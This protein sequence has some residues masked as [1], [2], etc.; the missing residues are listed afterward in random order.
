MPTHFRKMKSLRNKTKKSK[1]KTESSQTRKKCMNDDEIGATCKT[2][3]YSSYVGNFYKNKDHLKQFKLIG[4]RF[5]S[6]KEYNKWKTPQEKYTHFLKTV[7]SP[8][9]SISKNDYLIT[10]NFYGY[11]NNIWL[12][13]TYNENALKSND[14]SK[15]KSKKDSPSMDSIVVSGSNDA[16]Q[17]KYYVQHD[18]FRIKQEE[19]Y[20]KLIGY[21]TDYIAAN[22]KSP[23]AKALNCIY[24]SLKNGSRERFSLHAK[25]VVEEMDKFI[26]DDDVYGCLAALNS[27][28]TVNWCAPILWTLLPNEKNVKQ[29]ISH[30]YA[31]SL[32]IYD[33]QIYLED[34]NKTKPED[35]RYK[36]QVRAKYFEYIQR[37]FDACLGAQKAAANNLNAAD[38]WGVELELLTAMNCDEIKDEDPNGYNLLTDKDLENPDTFDFDWTQ[39]TKKLGYTTTPTKIVVGNKSSI[40]CLIRIMK[41]KWK[42]PAWRAYLMFIQFKQ[43]IRFDIHHRKIHFDFYNNFLE[44]QPS[45]MPKEIYPIFGLSFTFNSFLSEQYVEHNYNALYASYTQHLVDDLKQ[46]FINKLKRNTWLSPETKVAALNKL[47]KLVIHVGTPGKLREDPI[48]P[49]VDDDPLS[50]MGLLLKWKLKKTI[51]LE[52]KPIIDVPDID[53]QAFKLV[54]TQCYMVNAYYRPNSNS[55]YVP[56]AYL[57]KPFIDLEERG[58]EYNLVYIGYTLGHELSHALDDTGSKYDAE[59]NLNNWWTPADHKKFQA[60]VDDVIKQYEVFSLRDGIVF[61]AA[62]GAGEDLADI[63]GYALI[64]EYLMDNQVINAEDIKMKKINLSK[65][66]MNLAIQG[67][68]YVNKK[69]VKAQLKM[70]PH[71]MEK[72]RVNC[73]LSRLELF[74]TIFG[75]KKGDGMWWHNTDTIW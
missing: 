67:R 19:T 38:V 36:K 4:Q 2:G 21:V 49:Y 3:Q 74:R 63:S 15:S 13:T 46:L 43:M 42:T 51:A 24:N 25:L 62:P 39:F 40:R 71:P 73:P 17:S 32:G 9:S 58:L 64:E 12:K 34:N 65:L 52:G 23:K 41:E 68:Q 61:D 31:P 20:Y 66:Y 48:L 18:D 1:S 55:I 35:R 30:L 11:V 59:G 6:Q 60:K 27:N 10:N 44:G 72:Y 8:K 16:I 53:W 69:A 33:Y 7:F 5:K 50:N 47:N 75:I 14:K 70:N 26:A 22:P 29:Y 28:E 37:V 54:G 45:I 57:Q 56:L